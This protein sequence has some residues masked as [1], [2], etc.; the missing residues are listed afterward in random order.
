M[1][2][3][4]VPSQLHL[5]TNL[6]QL[7]IIAIAGTSI[8][9][10]AVAWRPKPR[11]TTGGLLADIHPLVMVFSDTRVYEYHLQNWVIARG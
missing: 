6:R 2:P 1:P 9:L 3:H 4:F 7:Q 8:D 10:I 11:D 5:N